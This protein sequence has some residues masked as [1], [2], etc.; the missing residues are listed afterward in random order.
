[1]L[2]QY[3]KSPTP[4]PAMQMNA[5]LQIL[6]DIQEQIR[7]ADSKAGFIAAFNVLLFGVV[8]THLDKL[9]TLYGSG[10]ETWAALI[11]LAIVLVSL[12][13][14][15]TV[16]SLALAISCVISRFGGG[17]VQ[18]RVFFGHIAMHYGKDHARYVRDIRGMADA[19]WV[20]QL[21]TQVVEVSRLALIKHRRARWAACSTFVSVLLWIVSLATM[22]SIFWTQAS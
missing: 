22:V 18:S 6:E 4:S 20:E 13:A 10:K 16:V 3:P 21:G 12:Y 15:F 14:V 19:D 9:R 1:M 11:A 7:F 17:G 5:C 2:E 8:A